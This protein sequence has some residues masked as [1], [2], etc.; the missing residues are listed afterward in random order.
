MFKRNCLL[1]IVLITTINIT[2][3]LLLSRS[4]E[5][6]KIDWAAADIPIVNELIKFHL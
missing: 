6:Q 4:N 3:I 5:I 1:I 2:C